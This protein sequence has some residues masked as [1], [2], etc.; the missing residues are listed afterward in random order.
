MYSCFE[1]TLTKF[2]T[3]NL[4]LVLTSF[5]KGLLSADPL[6]A[7]NLALDENDIT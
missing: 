3:T 2:S 5:W 1:K 6:S 7:D 4:I